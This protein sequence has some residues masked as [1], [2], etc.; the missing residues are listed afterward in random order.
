[1]LGQLHLCARPTPCLS[2]SRRYSAR[3]AGYRPRCPSCRYGR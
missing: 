3:R 1:L 2:V